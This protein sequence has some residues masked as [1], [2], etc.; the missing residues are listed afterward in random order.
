MKKQQH[1]A[2]KS[3]LLLVTMLFNVASLIFKLLVTRV[4]LELILMHVRESEYVS[5]FV[6][7]QVASFGVHLQRV[8][9]PQTSTPLPQSNYNNT[10]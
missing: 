10:G 2:Y 9:M 3:L 5:W 1:R 7:I 8:S 6:R 4:S